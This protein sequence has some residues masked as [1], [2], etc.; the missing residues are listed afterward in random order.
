MGKPWH[1]Q[2][3]PAEVTPIDDIRA[4]HSGYGCWCQ[5]RMDGEVIVHNS[6]DGR[7]VPERYSECTC[8]TEDGD[9]QLFGHHLSCPLYSRRDN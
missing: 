4:H 3:N 7:E 8:A 6:L 5:P 2:S 1:V 9:E